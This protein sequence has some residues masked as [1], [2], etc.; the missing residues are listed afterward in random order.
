MAVEEAGYEW[1]KVRLLLLG[2]R[3]TPEMLSSA[4]LLAS[5]VR[6]LYLGAGED[7]RAACYLLRS[8]FGIS[9]AAVGRGEC[10]RR[11]AERDTQDV[12]ILFGGAQHPPV[13]ENALVLNFT[14]ETPALPGGRVIDGAVL[15]PPR[16]MW[17]DWPAECDAGAMLAALL[18]TEQVTLG[19]IGIRGLKY[20]A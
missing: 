11:T 15:E 6:T 2:S 5:S 12:F 14:G 1:G 9:A 13:S 10:L 16:S 17:K 7:T 3:P 18:A 20:G 8:R 4:Q 19:E